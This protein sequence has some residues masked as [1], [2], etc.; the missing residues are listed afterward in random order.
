M[1]GVESA[2]DSRPRGQAKT[3]AEIVAEDEDYDLEDLAEAVRQ[4]TAEAL[5]K[6]NPKP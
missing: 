5:D 2:E 3:V 6:V 1:P 4:A